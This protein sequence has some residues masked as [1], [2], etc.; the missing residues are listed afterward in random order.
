LVDDVIEKN[1][2]FIEARGKGA[3][4]PLM[5]IIMKKARGRVKAKLVK[6]I[7]KSKLDDAIS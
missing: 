1:S 5:G 3:F 6:E 7:L 4:G 2:E